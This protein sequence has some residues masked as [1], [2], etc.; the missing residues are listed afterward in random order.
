MCRMTLTR[1]G[2]LGWDLSLDV[3]AHHGTGSLDS[4]GTHEGSHL[5]GNDTG[6]GHC[7]G[8]YVLKKR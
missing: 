7:K 1:E 5:G 8:V 6:S 2:T 3:G 4:G